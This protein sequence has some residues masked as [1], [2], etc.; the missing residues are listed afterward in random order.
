M[1]RMRL[2]LAVMGTSLVLAVAACSPTASGSPLTADQAAALVLESNPRFTGIAPRDP[3]L[4]GQAAWYEVGATADGWQVEVRMGWADCPA[5]CIFQHVWLYA[6]AADGAV[7]LIEESGDR[8]PAETGV[9]GTVSAGPTCPVVT[10][11]PDPACADRRVASAVLVVTDP[12]GQEVGRT[13]SAADG[14][15]SLAL[16]PGAYQLVPQPVQG[17]LGTAAPVAFSVEAGQAAT[18]LVVVYETGIR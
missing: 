8:L 1:D 2:I 15:F 6:V 13:T 11:P 14:S 10:V 3:N 12:T 17:L 9:Q 4:I 7:T 5:G 16:A 18:T